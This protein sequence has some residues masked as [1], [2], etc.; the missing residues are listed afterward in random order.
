MYRDAKCKSHPAHIAGNG[1]EQDYLSRFFAARRDCQ[2]HHIDVTWNYQLH[3]VP[4][5]LE[6]LLQ[7]RKR[8]Q[9]AQRE[10]S[11]ADAEWR[12]RRMQLTDQEIGN[13]HYSGDVKLWHMLLRT[14]ATEDRRRS[15][16]HAPAQSE[17]RERD[18]REF[19]HHL[20]SDQHSYALWVERTAPQEAYAELGCTRHGQR[21]FMGE[22][23]VTPLVDEMAHLVV[24][25]ATCATRIWR[26]S[27]DVLLAAR[28]GLLE[29]LHQPHVPK[30]SLKHGTRVEASYQL[31]QGAWAT[32]RWLEATVL[33]IHENGDYVLKY[34]RKDDWGDTERRVKPSRVRLAA[35]KS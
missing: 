9:D 11:Q 25:V 21:I 5:S 18:Y 26:Q 28:E 20:L 19:A 7:W 1:P 24:Q 2:W 16:D 29:D 17:A 23:D 3:H 30:G 13:V 32:T 4:F 31:G 14:S 6:R 35:P 27:A 10:I 22:E 12:P 33:A 34:G 8:M 15:V